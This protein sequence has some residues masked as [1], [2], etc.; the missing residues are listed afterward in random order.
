MF[1]AKGGQQQQQQQ[2]ITSSTY[3]YSL[4]F[5]TLKTYSWDNEEK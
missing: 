2:L 5:K 4:S 3:L 1:I